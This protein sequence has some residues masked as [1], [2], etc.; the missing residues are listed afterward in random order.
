MECEW[1]HVTYPVNNSYIHWVKYHVF[2]KSAC[3]CS[4]D[5]NTLFPCLIFHTSQKERL[6]GK[7]GESLD[8][9]HSAELTTN[10][11]YLYAVAYLTRTQPTG[12]YKALI[13]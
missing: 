12:L 5:K 8:F 6:L 11:P 3:V 10:K 9:F 2:K 1:M 7:T 4:R 13:L